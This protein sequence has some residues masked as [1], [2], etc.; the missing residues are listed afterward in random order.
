MWPQ[1]GAGL[2]KGFLWAALPIAALLFAAYFSVFLKLVTDWWQISDDS[3]GFV[4]VPFALYLLWK[5]RDVL[6]AGRW[7]GAWSGVAVVGIGLIILLAGIYGAELFLQ[8]VSFVIVLAGLTLAFGG[9]KLVYE[10]RYVLLVLLLAIPIP[11]IVMTKITLPLQMLSARLACGALPLFGIPVLREGNIIQL[12]ARTLEVAEACSGIRSLISLLTL[13]I[14]YGFFF[15]SS[16]WRRVALAVASIP[17][18]IA[19]NAVRLISTGLGVEYWNPDKAMGFF[20]EFSGWVLFLVAM[21]AL[22]LLH[23]LL[24]LLPPKARAA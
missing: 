24:L 14:I 16:I 19:A 4:V 8:R 5:K 12:S 13:A 20:H 6:S 1:W 3:H 21:A 18:A 2:S 11:A 15:E 7:R 17:I 22:V 9:R 10:L 23:R